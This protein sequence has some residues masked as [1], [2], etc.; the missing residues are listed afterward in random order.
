MT[1]TEY[2]Q[3]KRECWEEFKDAVFSGNTSYSTCSALDF[4]FDRAYALGREKEAI[5]QEEIVE[6]AKKYDS[7][8]AYYNSNDVIEC[9]VEGANFALGKQEKHAEETP[10]S[11]RL[12]E[13][14][15]S[16]LEWLYHYLNRAVD[17]QENESVS[18]A[19]LFEVMERL[20]D[21]FG[22]DLLTNG[23][24][25]PTPKDAETVIQGWVARDEV[26]IRPALYTSKPL[27]QKKGFENGYWSY[28]MQI[29]LSLDPSLFPDLTWSDEPQECEIIIKRKKK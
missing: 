13:E 4:A 8:H 28:G 29:G 7:E 11:E 27:R 24:G 19:I 21:M 25:K 6:A 2:D 12:Y 5:T 16:Q 23:H 3:K 17:K 26:A 15:K 1:Q 20:E 10:I 14:E 18:V 22:I 9:F